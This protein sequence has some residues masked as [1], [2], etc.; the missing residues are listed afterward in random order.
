MNIDKNYV[1]K[2]EDFEFKEGIFELLKLLQKKFVL[3]IVTNQSGIGRGYYSLDDFKKLT[4]YMLNEFKK[5]GIEIKEVAFCPHHPD[6]HCE[7][8]KPKPGM[9]L[10]LAKK[11]NIDLQHSIMIG[12]KLSDINAGI[13]AGIKKNYLVKNS[14]F[15]IIEKI[16]KL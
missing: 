3:F 8:R 7:C 2:I 15:D 9:I 12:D 4:Q 10:N 5:R 11:Y 6:E 16:K 13:N 1:Y 14:L